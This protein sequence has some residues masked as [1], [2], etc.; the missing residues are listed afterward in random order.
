MTSFGASTVSKGKSAAIPHR[1]RTVLRVLHG[2]CGILSD[3][4]LT[5]CDCE[6]ALRVLRLCDPNKSQCDSSLRRRLQAAA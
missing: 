6:I 5:E 1:N 3:C 4:S 2:L